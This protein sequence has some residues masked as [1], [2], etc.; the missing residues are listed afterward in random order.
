MSRSRMLGLVG[1]RVQGLG[2]LEF[3]TA[4][5][6]RFRVLGFRDELRELW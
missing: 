6:I 4:K 1:L 3:M 5:Q 2:A